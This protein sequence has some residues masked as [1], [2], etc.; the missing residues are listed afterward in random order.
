[1]NRIISTVPRVFS[2]IHSI[3]GLCCS[4]LGLCCSASPPCSNVV[5]RVERFLVPCRVDV[6]FSGSFSGSSSS[7]PDSISCSNVVVL[8]VGLFF[9][10]PCRVEVLFPCRVEVFLSGSFSGSSCSDLDSI[11]CCSVP[12]SCSNVVASLVELFF[13]V[14]YRVEVLFSCRLEIF[15]SGSF[16]GSSCSDLDSISCCSVPP[17]CSNDLLFWR[18]RDLLLLG[19]LVDLFLSGSFIRSLGCPGCSNVSA[20]S[21][22]LARN[23]MLDIVVCGMKA[24]FVLSWVGNGVLFDT[25][26]LVHSLSL[27]LSRAFFSD[28]A[29]GMFLETSAT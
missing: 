2:R 5:S 1:M 29:A 27:S 25:C 8:L 6:F 18:L 21:S 10:V 16:P 26:T 17:S 19:C 12:P 24:L 23:G 7:N 13:F 3:P 22:T 15:L 20:S 11:S 4:V 9:L 28:P 14:P